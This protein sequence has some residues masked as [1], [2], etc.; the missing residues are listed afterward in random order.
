MNP[1]KSKD[2]RT[3]HEVELTVQDILPRQ[4]YFDEDE[5]SW[6]KPPGQ[7][8]NSTPMWIAFLLLIDQNIFSS[9]RWNIVGVII[10]MFK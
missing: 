7:L 9:S 6:D 10:L 5:N 8:G 1:R 4:L 3:K 2:K